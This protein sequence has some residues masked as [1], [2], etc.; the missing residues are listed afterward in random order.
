VAAIESSRISGWAE[1]IVK[2]WNNQP[3]DPQI[4]QIEA[5][6]SDFEGGGAEDRRQKSGVRIQKTEDRRQK[7]EV[8]EYR[9]TGVRTANRERKFDE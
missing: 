8:Q 6:A 3:L 4:A 2:E 1:S 9:S 5:E 7:T